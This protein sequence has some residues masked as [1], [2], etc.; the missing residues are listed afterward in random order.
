[1]TTAQ[2][3]RFQNRT[4]RDENGCHIW[5]GSTNA[6]GYGQVRLGDKSVLVHRAAYEHHKGEIPVGNVVRH[7]CNQRACCN[8]EH[9]ETGTHAENMRDMALAGRHFTK[10]HPEKVIRGSNHYAAKLTED[11]VREIRARQGTDSSAVVAADYGISA[12]MICRIWRRET[13]AHV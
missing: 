8:P 9:L 10:T 3:T 7:R 13:W 4:I 2:L 6:N 12:S 11:Q 1:M 5:Q